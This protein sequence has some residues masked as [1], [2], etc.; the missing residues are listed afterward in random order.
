MVEEQLSHQEIDYLLRL[1][2]EEQAFRA[3][4]DSKTTTDEVIQLATEALRGSADVLPLAIRKDPELMSKYNQVKMLKGIMPP[5]VFE[6]AVK[7][8][9]NS[10]PKHKVDRD[11]LLVSMHDKLHLMKSL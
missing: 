9:I 4:A 1:V 5:G 11:G 8:A 7:Q 10:L 6:M 2:K 3:S